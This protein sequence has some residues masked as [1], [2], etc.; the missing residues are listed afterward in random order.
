VRFP[1]AKEALV[2]GP[3]RRKGGYR[4]AGRLMTIGEREGFLGTPWSSV[5]RTKMS[6]RQY[7]NRKLLQIAGH[8]R[9]CVLGHLSLRNLVAAAGQLRAPTA[10]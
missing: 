3:V 8:L 1:Q 9:K 4:F 5:G 6:A 2:Q 10:L 7:A